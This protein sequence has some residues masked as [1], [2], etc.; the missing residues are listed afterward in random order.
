MQFSAVVS[1]VKVR[2]CQLDVSPFKTQLSYMQ[3]LGF[4][5]ITT[6]GLPDTR[7]CHSGTSILKVLDMIYQYPT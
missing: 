3:E 2:Q 6:F 1:R 4:F 5:S 7:H